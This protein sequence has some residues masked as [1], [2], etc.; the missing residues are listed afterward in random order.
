MGLLEATPTTSTSQMR[1][2]NDGVG[3]GGQTGEQTVGG[4]RG[5]QGGGDCRGSG[6]NGVMG[7]GG[8]MMG[9]WG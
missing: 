3:S 1:M 9:R 8:D 5:E 4:D 7:D 2:G 6:G